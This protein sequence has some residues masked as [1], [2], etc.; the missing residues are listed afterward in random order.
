MITEE[1]LRAEILD[2]RQDVDLAAF[3]V[4]VGPGETMVGRML[5]GIPVFL[6][7]LPMPLECH[8]LIGTM[9]VEPGLACTELGA[10]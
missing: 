6:S 4:A 2:M 7:P 8:V 10:E 9:V 5:A 3:A 1:T